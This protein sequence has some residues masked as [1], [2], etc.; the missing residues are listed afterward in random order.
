MSQDSRSRPLAFT[1]IELVVVLA[2]IAI[3]VLLLAPAT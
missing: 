3:L 2:I 1:L